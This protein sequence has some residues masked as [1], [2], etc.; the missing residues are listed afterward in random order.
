M[1]A[2]GWFV[3]FL[4]GSMIE[5]HEWIDLF[6]RVDSVTKKET[7]VTGPASYWVDAASGLFHDETS[8]I[9]DESDASQ[10]AVIFQL[11][12]SVKEEDRVK[13][14]SLQYD[15]NLPLGDVVNEL[16]ETV[17]SIRYF[18]GGEN[19]CIKTIRPIFVGLVTQ[20]PG[21]TSKVPID[22]TFGGFVVHME[23]AATYGDMPD[24]TMQANDVLV[25][26]DAENKEETEKHLHVTTSSSGACQY[27][28][29]AGEKVNESWYKK[30]AANGAII[31]KSPEEARAIAAQIELH[32]TFAP[33]CI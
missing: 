33:P 29:C 13:P 5:Q 24:A 20:A 19:T 14:P 15:T 25:L 28:I 11:W 10:H 18:V 2:K 23:G 6:K 4:N 1:R 16:G 12:M 3:V 17:G 21:T 22:P 31:A 9:T 27:L 26:A 30:L 8:V 32:K 7:T